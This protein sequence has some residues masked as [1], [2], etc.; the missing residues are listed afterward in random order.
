MRVCA[1]W[2]GSASRDLAPEKTNEIFVNWPFDASFTTRPM[3]LED[4]DSLP[5]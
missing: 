1:P 5:Y 4:D 3:P 2:P